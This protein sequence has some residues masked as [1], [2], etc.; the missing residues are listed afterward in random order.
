VDEDVPGEQREQEQNDERCDLFHD[1]SS[2]G[3]WAGRTAMV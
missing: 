1:I 2:C 3:G